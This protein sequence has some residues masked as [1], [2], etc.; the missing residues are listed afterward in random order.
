MKRSH[1]AYLSRIHQD[2]YAALYT[3]PTAAILMAAGIR[4]EAYY[5]GKRWLVLGHG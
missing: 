4:V 3:D 1:S 2:A 5:G